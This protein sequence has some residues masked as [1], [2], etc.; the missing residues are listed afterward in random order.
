MHTN[1][2]AINHYLL[3]GVV[4]QLLSV[5]VVVVLAA[6]SL[7][8]SSPSPSPQILSSSLAT[9]PSRSCPRRRIRHHLSPTF[10]MIMPVVVVGGGARS[11]MRMRATFMMQPSHRHR[12]GR[13]Q[14]F[15]QGVATLRDRHNTISPTLV[16]QC[17]GDMRRQVLSAE[18]SCN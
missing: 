17:I 12:R 2:M 11:T 9:L 7:P 5:L 4:I 8:K 3:V 10:I 13:R 6:S 18:I 16:S 14:L 1:F 15:K